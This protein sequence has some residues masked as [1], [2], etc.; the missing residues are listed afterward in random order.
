MNL[1]IFAVIGLIILIG[2]SLGF[3]TN[4]SAEEDLIPAWIKNNAGWWADDMIEDSD[5]AQGI[6]FLMNEGIIKKNDIPYEFLD[7]LKED[8]KNWSKGQISDKEFL[9]VLEE[10]L[11]NPTSRVLLIPKFL[12]NP[13]NW[14]YQE[15]ILDSEF[16]AVNKFVVDNGVIIPKT[17]EP[18]EI[19]E[20]KDYANWWSQGAITDN[21][22]IRALKTMEQNNLFPDDPSSGTNNI[23]EDKAIAS[24]IKAVWIN[25]DNV[26][27]TVTS[28]TWEK[29][30]GYF[31]SSLLQPGA[32]YETS[33][34]SGVYS[35]FCMIHP[36]NVGTVTV[37]Q[38]Q[39]GPPQS[40]PPQS[41]SPPRLLPEV[42]F[43][44]TD[45]ITYQKNE[46]IFLSGNIEGL[47][48]GQEAKVN[49]I[50]LDP[51]GNIL[52]PKGIF[53]DVV[54]KDEFDFTL[55]TILFGIEGIYTATAY[56]Q[57]EDSSVSTNFGYFAEGSEAET[58]TQIDPPSLELETGPS[59]E[60]TQKIPDW[61][62]NIF[63]WY[64]EEKVSEAELL[65]SIKYL[66]Q[67]EIITLD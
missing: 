6:T 39:Q 56:I 57:Y 61:V 62:R 12:V 16:Y 35:Y 19:D 3:S 28:G 20:L 8:A 45:K 38:T 65:N 1:I 51:S 18:I 29:I 24:T 7:Y 44:T 66:V 22:Y 33:L 58:Q 63:I 32:K 13:A 49:L 25:D 50:I 47:K 59:H 54:L 4:V 42:S 40:V 17:F 23:V 41:P 36:W 9:Q 27:H 14:W 52:E 64:A 26:A 43:L 46:S 37:V 15:L 5:F 34:E 31:D 11:I 53:S 48:Y 67:Q 30:D 10:F 21:D 55:H 2:V 60:S